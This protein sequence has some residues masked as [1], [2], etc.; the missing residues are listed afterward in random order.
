M[1]SGVA[2]ARCAGRRGWRSV[3]ARFRRSRFLPCRGVR[4][5]VLA[6]P[7]LGAGWMHGR[8]LSS[9]GHARRLAVSGVA[10]A[11]RRRCS[12]SFA[13][14]RCGRGRVMDAGVFPW[15]TDPT[16][17]AEFLQAL[18]VLTH[19][20]DYALWP[21]SP[22]LMHAQSLF[23]LGAAGRRR[24][25][26]LPADAGPDAG[27]PRW[28]RL[29]YAVDDARGPTVGFIAN[30][31]VL[32]A[33]TFGVSA[34]SSATIA[35]GVTDRG[36]PRFWPWLLLAAALFSQGRGHRHLRLPGGLWSLRRPGRPLARVPGTGALCRRRRRLADAPRPLGITVCTTW[37]FMLTR[38]PIPGRSWR[39][40]V[41]AC[42]S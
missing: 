26:L 36:R 32:V 18:T 22:V 13:A 29:L 41:C 27:S 3:L 34:R 2:I 10:R 14:T 12:G 20:L 28:P 19:R 7:A 35:G 17:K 31:N 16:L 25:H 40:V 6:L 30:R 38:S 23:W 8:L 11:A 9:G 33:A 5:I 42:R 4:R 1:S 24:R 21:D 15:W 39:A 37:G